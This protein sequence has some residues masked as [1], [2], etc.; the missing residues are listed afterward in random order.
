MMHCTRCQNKQKCLK[1]SKSVKINL[2]SSH[3]RHPFSAWKQYPQPARKSSVHLQLKLINHSNVRDESV[4][5]YGNCTIA[6]VQ[7]LMSLPALVS[8]ANRFIPISREG[9]DHMVMISKESIDNGND[10]SEVADKGVE[11]PYKSPFTVSLLTVA[12]PPPLLC[13]LTH[14]TYDKYSHPSSSHQSQPQVIVSPNN[15]QILNKQK[16]EHC[17]VFWSQRG[18]YY[19]L[20]SNP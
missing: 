2:L 7:T 17:T 9:E 12:S 10:W 14:I 13:I 15:Q 3:A 4:K 8:P 18:C 1:Q 20:V 11:S 16:G 19:R 5:S 6:M